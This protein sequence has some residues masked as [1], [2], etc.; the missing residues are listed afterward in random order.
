MPHSPHF[1]SSRRRFIISRHGK[2]GEDGAVRY[3]GRE[4]TFAK[5]SVQH[6]VKIFISYSLLVLVVNLSLYLI[7]ELNSITGMCIEKNTIQST[8]EQ[9]SFELCGSTYTRFFFFSKY[10]WPFVSTGFTCMDSTNRGS[11]TVFSHFQLQIPNYGSKMLVLILSWLT[12]W[13]QRANCRAKSY[14][15]SAVWAS[16]PLT[17]A[18]F[19]GQL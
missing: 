11:E 9:R 2:K 15:F 16:E 18:W 13:T 5:R 8:L 3:C 19:K 14:R 12:P 6:I 10:N 1:I 17:L 7:Y 4:T